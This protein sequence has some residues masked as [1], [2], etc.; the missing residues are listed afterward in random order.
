LVVKTTGGGGGGN[1]ASGQFLFDVAVTAA[2]PGDG[3]LRFNN[4]NV[5]L[6]TE[7]YIDKLTTNAIDIGLV[8]ENLATDDEFRIQVA[9]DDDNNGVYRLTGP[10]VDNVGW[11][12]LPVAFKYFAGD[13]F[14]D[15]V[16]VVATAIIGGGA[17]AFAATNGLTLLGNLLKWGGTVEEL[18]TLD[19]LPEASIRIIDHDTFDEILILEVSYTGSRAKLRSTNKT[20]SEI[21]ELEA[22]AEND[23]FQIKDTRALP[24]GLDGENDYSANYGPNTYVQKGWIDDLVG[25]ISNNID[26]GTA[27]SIYNTVPGLD[28]GTP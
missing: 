11:W 28:G 5:G 13:P 6:V 2:D 24:R 27:T 9:A 18:T 17:G 4:V 3:K 12:T 14:T 8:L 23:V 25:A 26:G 1:S 7:I 22:D 21:V 10:A 19:M 16:P 20:N 15:L